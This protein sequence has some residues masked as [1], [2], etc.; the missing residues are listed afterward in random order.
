MR[1]VVGSPRDARA[2]EHHV[3]K[4]HPTEISTE[5]WTQVL[6]FRFEWGIV[7]ARGGVLGSVEIIYSVEFGHSGSRLRG[8]PLTHTM[9]RNSGKGP[10]LFLFQSTTH[11]KPRLSAVA[12]RSGAARSLE[13]WMTRA[14]ARA[15]VGIKTSAGE[16]KLSRGP[17]EAETGEAGGFF[18]R[19]LRLDAG[20]D[21]VLLRAPHQVVRTGTTR[22]RA[23]RL[24]SVR[25][26]NFDS[27]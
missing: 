12:E 27:E 5:Y 22:A 18:A 24:W 2:L 19:V 9:A 1:A 13:R 16:K 6:A 15:R 20:P 11:I 17:V 10:R 7:A 21:A 23:R 14:R 3:S 8:E 4:Q 26:L 25:V